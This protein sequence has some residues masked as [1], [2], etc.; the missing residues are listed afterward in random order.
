M[1]NRT[2]LIVDSTA[3]KNLCPDMYVSL[4][5]TADFKPLN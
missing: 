5:D 3:L 2:E 4:R 1:S